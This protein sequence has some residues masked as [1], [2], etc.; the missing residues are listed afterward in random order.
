MTL[1]LEE[2]LKFK[3]LPFWQ[4]ISDILDF[5]F[6]KFEQFLFTE[7]YHNQKSEPLKMQKWQLF[8]VLK[9]QK[10]ISRKISE[11]KLNFP[12]CDMVQGDPNKNFMT[13]GL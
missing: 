11:E 1:M 3:N 5:K 13:N 9:S 12:P 7:N 4:Y 6:D 10:L 8:E 2:F